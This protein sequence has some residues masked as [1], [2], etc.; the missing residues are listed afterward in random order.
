MLFSLSKNVFEKTRRGDA[1]L[2]AADTEKNRKTA[3]RLTLNH[4]A[5]LSLAAKVVYNGA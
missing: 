1:A 2:P 5:E 4:P 3:S